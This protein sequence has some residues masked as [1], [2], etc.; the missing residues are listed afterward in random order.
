MPRDAPAA[1]A[2]WLAQEVDLLVAGTG[3]ATAGV[4]ADLDGDDG[5]PGF[6]ESGDNGRVSQRTQLVD[7][8]S[9]LQDLYATRE[10]LEPGEAYN[11]LHSHTDSEEL[12]I[13]L[14]GE[15]MIRVNERLLPFRAA[16]CFGKP[17]GSSTSASI[18]WTRR[19]RAV[20]RERESTWAGHCC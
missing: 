11:R 16:Q 6:E 13:L 20:R 15:G 14:E 5:P 4:V 18:A 19:W 1:L 10:T 9:G 12:Y 17:C 3:L 8:V 2:D 7:L